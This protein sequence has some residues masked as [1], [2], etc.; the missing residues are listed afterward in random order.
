MLY[1]VD[2]AIKPR[3][4]ARISDEQIAQ[5]W[6]LYEGYVSQLN[7]LRDELAMLRREGKVGTALYA[8]RRRR[9]GFEYN[10][11]VLHEYYFANL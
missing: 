2:S 6:H 11:M 10:G 7:A 4:L 1:E 3:G 8:D 5:H 9:L